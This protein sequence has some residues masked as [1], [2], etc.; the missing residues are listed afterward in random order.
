MPPAVQQQSPV[1][2]SPVPNGSCTPVGHEVP[3]ITGPI[4]SVH[5]QVGSVEPSAPLASSTGS[6]TCPSS[7]VLTTQVPNQPQVSQP[8]PDPYGPVLIICNDQ[9]QKICSKESSKEGG[10]NAEDDKKDGMDTTPVRDISCE[11]SHEKLT[12][13]SHNAKPT[14][15]E[16]TTQKVLT[17]KYLLGE[18]KTLVANQGEHF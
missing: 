8:Q 4:C 17:V 16:K 15:P 10:T 18:L 9:E 7:A 12:V 6:S 11:T 2:V 1:T 5:H 14:S 3:V 13:L